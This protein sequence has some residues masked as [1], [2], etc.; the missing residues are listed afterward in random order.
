M[1]GIY[2]KVKGSNDWYIRYPNPA[3]SGKKIR[4]RIGRFDAAVEA[5]VKRRQEIRDGTFRAP[6]ERKIV[7][8]APEEPKQAPTF[9]ELFKMRMADLQRSLSDKTFRHHEYDFNSPHMESLKTMQADK[10][11]PQDVEIVLRGLHKAGRSAPTVRNYRS[12]ISA[13]FR[14]GILQELLSRNPV[15]KTKPPKIAKERVRFLSK[16][17]EGAIRQKIR[18]FWPEREAEFDLLIHSG[19]RSGESYAMTWDRIDLE[20]DVLSV[21]DAG[22][23]GWRD[24]PINSVC[25]KALQKL[26]E[27]S[28][29]SEFV[30]P[31][32]GS[33]NWMLNN[34]FG[35][36]VKK[37][38]VLH[39]TPHTLRH[40]FASRLVMAGVHLRTVQQFL[41]HASIVQ[42]MKYSHLSPE[43]GQAEIERLV[44]PAAP[45]RRAA[46][47]RRIA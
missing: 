22:K 47:V 37:A 41:G 16:D 10:I 42:T 39:A 12:L 20:R 15:L 35:D 4:E 23:T 45:T 21:P 9:E 27:Q 40:T 44:T 38:G 1:R 36:V 34:W 13:V 7:V 5:L 25:H 14:Y 17:E 24:V 43:H 29:G 2:E 31:R 28:R 26:H 32:C 11:R 33:Q 46:K 19:M 6:N 3:A 8:S 30:V 18:E